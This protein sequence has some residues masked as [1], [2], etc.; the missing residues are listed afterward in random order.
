MLKYIYYSL[1]H[2]CSVIYELDLMMLKFY[3]RMSDTTILLVLGPKVK[4]LSPLKF[5]NELFH[6]LNWKSQNMHQ[7]MNELKMTIQHN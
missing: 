2:A 6:P 1:S 4:T 5:P 3:V 7:G